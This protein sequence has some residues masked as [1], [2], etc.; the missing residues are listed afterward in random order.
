MLILFFDCSFNVF[1]SSNFLLIKSFKDCIFILILL[2]DLNIFSDSSFFNFNA[3]IAFLDLFN[4]SS[5]D[6]IKSCKEFIFKLLLF[7]DLNLFSNS[8]FSNFNVSIVFLDLFNSSSF[9]LIIFSK[10]FILFKFLSLSDFNSI[11]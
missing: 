7:N 4:S 2:N 5:F 11:I 8:S 1:N 9:D 6:L 10:D 3:S